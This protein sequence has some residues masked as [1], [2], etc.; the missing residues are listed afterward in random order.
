MGFLFG[1]E[2]GGG[3]G[4]F[5]LI[6]FAILIGGFILE[7]IM[8]KRRGKQ[9]EGGEQ[10]PQQYARTLR[11]M[12]LGYDDDDDDDERPALQ[13]RGRAQQIPGSGFLLVD[14][15]TI[16]LS[17]LPDLTELPE[18]PPPVDLPERLFGGRE[19][20]YT[21]NQ[22]AIILQEVLGPG[23]YRRFRHDGLRGLFH[24]V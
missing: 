3:G 11:R 13:P 1:D 24:R 19:E 15:P 9:Q 16:P 14:K 22:Q 12:A 18:P 5:Q 20:R 6:F 7:A 4:I 8:R 21:P 2:D 17:D 23:R 10:D